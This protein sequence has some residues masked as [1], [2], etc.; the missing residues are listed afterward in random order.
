MKNDDKLL[1]S[2]FAEHRQEI[3]DNGFTCRVMHHLPGR[4][5]RLER[6]WSLCCFTLTLVLFIA[7]DGAQLI[8]NALRETFEATLQTGAAEL[9]PKSVL[10]AGAV[11]LCFCYR[12]I[13]S[14][15]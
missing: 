2:F 13:A 15:V 7:L 4:V 3:A 1:T 12:K 9:Q 5:N 6:L 14:L 10:I 11:L 8:W